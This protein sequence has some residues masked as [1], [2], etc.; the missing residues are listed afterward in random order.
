MD[1]GILQAAHWPARM[2]MQKH[3]YCSK[4]P[5]PRT[6]LPELAC[7]HPCTALAVLPQTL[8]LRLKTACG[9][10]GFVTS[11]SWNAFLNCT[12]PIA[13]T[14]AGRRRKLQTFDQLGHSAAVQEHISGVVEGSSQS[15]GSSSNQWGSSGSSWD[16]SAPPPWGTMGG[17]KF[18]GECVPCS[19]CSP[20]SLR[21]GMDCF[22][23]LTSAFPACQAHQGLSLCEHLLAE[24][25]HGECSA[26]PQFGGCRRLSI[27]RQRSGS[28]HSTRA[29][30]AGTSSQPRLR[31]QDA[32]RAGSVMPVEAAGAWCGSQVTQN[33]PAR[34]A[35]DR[36]IVNE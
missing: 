22:S 15:W 28:A 25:F 33:L 3:G 16:S 21:V 29:C 10:A 31:H 26:C 24:T 35:W 30:C 2:Y 34:Q 18:F 8:H 9:S 23:S 5:T 19:P 14:G 17:F 4:F 27:P 13:G 6:C 32:D 36:L 7:K 20:E 1:L 11:P 12:C